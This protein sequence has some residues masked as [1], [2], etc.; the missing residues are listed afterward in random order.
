MSDSP[1][2]CM[3]LVHFL[4]HSQAQGTTLK[5][6]WQLLAPN[7]RHVVVVPNRRR[8]WARF[9][10]TIFSTGQPLSSGQLRALFRESNYSRPQPKP[11]HCTSRLLSG[12][13]YS[14]E[15]GRENNYDL[16]WYF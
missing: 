13:E 7:G 12:A 4:E 6:L 2:D 9:E 11:R 3:L 10:H 8:L 15:E 16:T 1:V 14:L 5:E